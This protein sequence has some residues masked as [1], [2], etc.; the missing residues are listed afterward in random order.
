MLLQDAQGY[1]QMVGERAYRLLQLKPQGGLNGTGLQWT[2]HC[3]DSGPRVDQVTLKDS[4]LGSRL[5]QTTFR[6]GFIN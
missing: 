1:K 2:P 5:K 3:R 6:D 4:T